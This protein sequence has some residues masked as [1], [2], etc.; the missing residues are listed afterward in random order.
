[1]PV[2]YAVL[3]TNGVQC[4]YYMWCL[5]WMVC[6]ACTTCYAWNEWCAMLVLYVMLEMNGVQCLYYM[7]CL[8]WMVCNACTMCYVWNEWCAMCVLFIAYTLVLRQMFAHVLFM[9]LELV[10]NRLHAEF[11]SSLLRYNGTKTFTLPHLIFI[12]LLLVIVCL[13]LIL[14][15]PFTPSY[16]PLVGRHTT[17]L[18]SPCIHKHV[19]YLF[20]SLLSFGTS[21][22]IILVCINFGTCKSA[23][24]AFLLV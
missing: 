5:K 14:P 22:F 10:Q 12:P 8:K 1:M 3:E 13:V 23:P 7:L 24:L 9:Y 17:S 21:D 19:G 15:H 4:S 11:K 20:Y 16:H 2:L 6:N 18:N